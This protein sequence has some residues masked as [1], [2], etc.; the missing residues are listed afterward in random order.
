MPELP[1]VQTVINYLNSKVLNQKIVDIKVNKEKFLKNISKNEFINKLKNQ[2]IKFIERIGKY[3]IFNISNNLFMVVHLRMEGKFFVDSELEN[4]KHDYIIFKLE[5]NSYL[6]YNDSR[7]FG[8]FHIC[9]DLNNLKEVK[10]IAI[11]PLDEKFN[12]DYLKPILNKSKKNIKI[13][14][15]DQEIISGI[16]NI[17][18]SEILFDAKINPFKNANELNDQEISSLID[19]SK[20][21]LKLALKYNGTTIHSFSFGENKT[22]EFN[23]HLKVVY[24]HDKPCIN[25]KNK[26]IR[27]KQG[28]RSTYYC[29]H[30]Q[31]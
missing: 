28:S 29:E 31:K 16:G 20:R 8:T 3:L 26:I 27:T 18:A 12:F 30:C 25:C 19:S 10:K 11:D 22:G 15:L 13:L 1:E 5:N 6:T 2:E 21:I 17:Y 9:H 23:K 14:L 24:Q 4:R 7:Q